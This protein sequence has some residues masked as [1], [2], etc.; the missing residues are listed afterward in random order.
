MWWQA[1]STL[2]APD[3]EKFES[4]SAKRASQ[5]RSAPAMRLLQLGGGLVGPSRGEAAEGLDSD[6]LAI[7]GLL[8]TFRRRTAQHVGA[9]VR[10]DEAF[11]PDLGQPGQ[12][13]HEIQ[14]LLDPSLVD[15]CLAD[16]EIGTACCRHQGIGPFGIAR[17]GKDLAVHSCRTM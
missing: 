10:E 14:V 4:S 8:A 9:H 11:R 17:V 5:F 15:I 12:Q 1:S 3:R 7:L 16:E 13:G 6:H 2:V